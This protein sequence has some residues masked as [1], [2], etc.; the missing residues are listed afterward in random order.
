MRDLVLEWLKSRLHLF[1]AQFYRTNELGVFS[2]LCPLT[3]WV[4]AN[5]GDSWRKVRVIALLACHA[6]VFG[7]SEQLLWFGTFLA[8]CAVSLGLFSASFESA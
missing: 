2:P 3:I 7:C 4:C 6:T 8:R 5:T 1:L